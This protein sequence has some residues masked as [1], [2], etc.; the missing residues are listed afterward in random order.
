MAESEAAFL[1]R[2]AQR[3]GRPR[4]HPEE[5]Q[6]PHYPH[7]PW[8]RYLEAHA[9]LDLVQLFV[10]NLKR[11]G[12]EAVV[13]GAEEELIPWLEQQVKERGW[14]SAALWSDPQL[15]KVGLTAAL[16][17]A[18]LRYAVWGEREETDWVMEAERADVGITWADGAYAETGT[19]L[20]HHHTPGRGR[21]VSLLPDV[22]LAILRR[23]QVRPRLSDAMKRLD[24]WSRAG[25]LASC[26]NFISGPSGS[27]DIQMEY[28]F[29]V[30]GPRS[31][32]VIL[33][34]PVDERGGKGN[35]QGETAGR[36][37]P[38]DPGSA[39]SDAE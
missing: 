5:V 24:Q 32:I 14:Q 31:L 38:A 30:H 4:Q 12:G 37:A 11:L 6:R 21:V 13:L 1:E 17:A 8:E 7:W 34:P 2:V 20:L 33:L 28:V 35:G 15:E 18:G 27:A 22:H 25:Q 26:T 16:E 10:E 3:L 36:S 29:G 23:D 9:H 19:I 39:K